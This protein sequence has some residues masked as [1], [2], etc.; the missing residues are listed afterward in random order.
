MPDPGSQGDPPPNIWQI[1]Q[2]YSN[3]GR[4]YY[5]HIL[6]LSSHFFSPSDITEVCNLEKLSSKYNNF[7]LQSLCKVSLS[8]FSKLLWVYS[9]V[10][11]GTGQCNFLGQRNR[12]SFIVSEKGTTGQA[13]SLATGRDGTGFFTGCPGEITFNFVH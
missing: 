10:S 4:V 6:L 12:S 5:P 9:R 11:N 13:Q 8:G 3:L 2:P 1:S 7:K